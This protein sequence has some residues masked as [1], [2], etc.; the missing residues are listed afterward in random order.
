MSMQGAVIFRCFA[1]HLLRCNNAEEAIELSEKYCQGLCSAV[2]TSKSGS[3]RRQ[4]YKT[5][6]KIGSFWSEKFIHELSLFV[7]AFNQSY[8]RFNGNPVPQKI[9]ETFSRLRMTYIDALR[10]YKENAI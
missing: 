5:I 3:E 8:I 6:I 10:T 1:R 9:A 7:D 2:A 4:F